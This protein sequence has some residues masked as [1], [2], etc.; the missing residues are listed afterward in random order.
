VPLLASLAIPDVLRFAE[1]LP[2]GYPNG[3]QLTDHTTDLLI[4]L[5]VQTDKLG[6]PK[7]TDGTQPKESCPA[8]P[9]LG[10]PLQLND[11]TIPPTQ[12]NPPPC[13]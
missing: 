12:P 13:L 4:S 3:R 2:D 7:F 5:I 1:N 9:F 11:S 8:F 6:V 10:P